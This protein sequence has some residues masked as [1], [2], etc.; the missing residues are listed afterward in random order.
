MSTK[1]TTEELETPAV[2]PKVFN[3]VVADQNK[4]VPEQKSNPN[5]PL[6][7]G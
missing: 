4:S 7:A 3:Y 6:A 2:E 1:K 5:S